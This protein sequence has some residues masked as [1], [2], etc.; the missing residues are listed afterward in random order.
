[1]RNFATILAST[2]LIAGSAEAAKSLHMYDPMT[3]SQT[4]GPSNMQLAQTVTMAPPAAEAK[5]AAAEAKATPA[6]TPAA[7]ND[8]A[9]DA[10]LK[11]KWCV[12][13]VESTF[14]NADGVPR[15]ALEQFSTFVNQI[16][17]QLEAEVP[18]GVVVSQCFHTG[19]F[20]LRE[21]RPLAD[22]AKGPNGV[23]FK[24]DFSNYVDDFCENYADVLPRRTGFVRK[25]NGVED[26][27][28]FQD[29]CFAELAENPKLNTWFDPIDPLSSIT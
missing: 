23:Q 15:T 14:F 8:P 9:Q 20:L 11:K 10:A 1:M 13:N 27:S 7:K 3:L 17:P 29:A 4:Y 26:A 16:C 28:E 6:P 24:T 21:L 19:Y 2:A 5:P 25:I 12:E 18:M 22:N